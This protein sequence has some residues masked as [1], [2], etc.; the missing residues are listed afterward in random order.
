M[1]AAE[2]GEMQSLPLPSGA[3]AF[4]MEALDSQWLLA[5]AATIVPGHAGESWLWMFATHGRDG[6]DVP[7]SLWVSNKETGAHSELQLTKNWQWHPV[8]LDFPEDATGAFRWLGLR[9]EP[10]FDPGL[11]H[12]PDNL[13]VRVHLIAVSPE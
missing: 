12:F 3:E 9:T 13:G 4:G 1:F 6:E 11:S 10:V 7:V 8:R 2:D 5:E